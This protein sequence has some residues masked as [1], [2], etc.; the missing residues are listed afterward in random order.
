MT[1]SGM[2]GVLND[3]ISI[4]FLDAM[5]ASGSSPVGALGQELRP[6]AAC[7]ACATMSRRRELERHHTGCP[8]G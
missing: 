4:Y 8:E 6:I 7:S 3:A 5:L 2:R 1:P